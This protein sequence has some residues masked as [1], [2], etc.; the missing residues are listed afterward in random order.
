MDIGTIRQEL[1]V[2]AILLLVVV[3]DTHVASY[4]IMTVLHRR[5]FL[6]GWLS[7]SHLK[8]PQGCAQAH[9]S[10]KSLLLI[11]YEI[12]ESQN[13]LLIVTQMIK[14]YAILMA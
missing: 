13:D 10:L 9:T 11:I 1:T 12:I 6:L 5:L 3:M 8:Q 4:E 14:T 7:V 2:L